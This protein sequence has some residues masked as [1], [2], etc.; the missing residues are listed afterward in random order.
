MTPMGISTVKSPW[1]SSPDHPMRGWSPG[2]RSSPSRPPDYVPT[3]PP[4]VGDKPVPVHGS[5]GVADLEAALDKGM[6]KVNS[7]RR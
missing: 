1:N 5:G 2:S 3:P 7:R 4:R 6:A